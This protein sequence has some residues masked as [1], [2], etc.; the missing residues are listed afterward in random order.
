MSTDSD[1]TTDS[2]RRW[3]SP[4]IDPSN[5]H[6]EAQGTYVNLLSVR[7]PSLR[8]SLIIIQRSAQDTPLEIPLSRE[9][10]SPSPAGRAKAE[11]ILRRFCPTREAT[12]AILRHLRQKHAF[13]QIPPE[14]ELQP[15]DERCVSPF[16]SDGKYVSIAQR[17]IWS[18]C[19]PL[20]MFCK[21]PAAPEKNKNQKTEFQILVLGSREYQPD[22]LPPLHPYFIPFHSIPLTTRHI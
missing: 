7:C 22:L 9:R 2:R 16:P 10:G 17:E 13:R 14:A 18:A 8:W 12:T 1:S 19:T 20:G 21:K 15:A 11:I 4:G 6:T 3:S 5:H